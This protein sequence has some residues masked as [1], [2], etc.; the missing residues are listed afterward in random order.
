MV[1]EVIEGGFKFSFILDYLQRLAYDIFSRRILAELRVVE[2][3]AV[4]LR[5]A[6]NM[7][8]PNPWDLA[9]ARG[10]SAEP[11]AKSALYGLLA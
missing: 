2:A 6:L 3:C 7:V 9:S 10:V 11:H 5:D 4:T 1:Q 8:A